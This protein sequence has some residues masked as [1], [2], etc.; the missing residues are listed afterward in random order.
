[1]TWW[2]DSAETHAGVSSDTIII[3]V[4]LTNSGILVWDISDYFPIF[5]SFPLIPYTFRQTPKYFRRHSDDNL[6]HFNNDLISAD[7]SSVFG[8]N[9]ANESYNIFLKTFTSLYDKNVP[10]IKM[11]PC[12]RKSPSRSPWITPALLKS[13]NRKNRLYHKFLRSPSDHNRSIYIRYKNFLT[14]TLRS[15]K[16]CITL[17]NLKRRKI[18]STNTWKIINNVLKNKSFSKISSIC[19]NNLTV[20]NSAHIAEDFNNS[21]V[22]V[23][24]NLAKL[25]P[26]CQTN[27]QD[28]LLESNPHSIFFTPLTESEVVSIVFNLPSKRSSGHDSITCPLIKQ[29]FHA[30]C[31]PLTFII[32]SSLTSGVVPDSMKIARVM[33]IFKSGDRQLVNN[34]RPISILSSFSK[35][36]ERAVYIRTSLFFGK[37]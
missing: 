6:R 32:N 33:P 3:H 26:N 21:F 1:M 17:N 25:I 27:F 24:P 5:T 11:K 37:I 19:V 18:T 36:L 34:Y 35:I 4:E 7:C 20:N 23:G 28:F 22:N 13:I 2:T 15:T 29:V 10:L 16:K 31:K 30:I 8:S 9:D 14:T 12:Y